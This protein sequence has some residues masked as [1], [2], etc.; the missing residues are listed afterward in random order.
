M[1]NG[2]KDFL[3]NSITFNLFDFPTTICIFVLLLH[4]KNAAIQL[5]ATTPHY[6]KNKKSLATFPKEVN[7]DN[8]IW[9]QV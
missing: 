1:L 2:Q 5:N 7:P 4:L 3:K 6:I 9:V 8:C